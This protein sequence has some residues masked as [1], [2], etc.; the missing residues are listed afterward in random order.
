[1]SS[2][3]YNDNN[4]DRDNNIITAGW[5]LF[6]PEILLFSKKKKKRCSV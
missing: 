6:Q 3:E 2:G 4:K 1:M 5:K